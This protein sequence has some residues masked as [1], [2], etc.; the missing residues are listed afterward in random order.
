MN[1]RGIL[2]LISQPS[3]AGQEQVN[4]R[5]HKRGASPNTG[6]REAAKTA[7]ELS[8]AAAGDQEWRSIRSLDQDQLGIEIKFR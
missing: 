2:L 1:E 4:A 7:G 5:E 8:R 3:E 6:K